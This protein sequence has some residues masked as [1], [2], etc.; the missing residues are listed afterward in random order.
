MAR[1]CIARGWSAA[2]LQAEL[3]KLH[4]LPVSFTQPPEQMTAAHGWTVDGIDQPIGFEPPGPP[5]PDGPFAR[6]RQALIRY[7]FSDPHMVVG[8][9]DPRAPLLGRDMLLE[10][11]VPGLRFLVGVRV[12]AVLAESDDHRSSFGFRYDTLEGHVERGYEWFVLSKNHESGQVRVRIEAHW[13]L[14]RFPTWWSRLGFLLVGSALRE[15]WRR[16]AISRLRQLAHAAPRR[17]SP[18]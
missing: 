12:E 1:W 2:T 11:K 17:T 18:A 4:D 6:A 7:D 5:L 8:H 10:V 14:A 3:R 9:F 16:R 13:Q 15:R